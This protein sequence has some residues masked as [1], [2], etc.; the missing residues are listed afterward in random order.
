MHLSR[1]KEL[2]RRHITIM[3][4][5]ED[6]VR[7]TML[8]I[9]EQEETARIEEEARRRI[10]L[11]K[12]SNLIASNDL[13]IL[14]SLAGECWYTIEDT[15]PYIKHVHSR[16]RLCLVGPN[17]VCTICQTT[18]SLV[19]G[20]QAREKIIRILD[21]QAA[22]PAYSKVKPLLDYYSGN[23]HKLLQIINTDYRLALHELYNLNVDDL[24]VNKRYMG[25][26]IISEL[27]SDPHEVI[28]DLIR[29]E[30]VAKAAID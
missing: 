23:N 17:P 13:T 19:F 28:V 3:S 15:Y 16:G 1:Y 20:K 9:L 10:Q 8:R 25:R 2:H 4:S 12:A 22:L 21:G 27:R 7:D 11:E 5:Y 26:A 18:Q 14:S 30:K 24:L 29:A 6:R